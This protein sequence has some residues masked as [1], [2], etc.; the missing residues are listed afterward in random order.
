MTGHGDN[1]NQ[2]L[3]TI[4]SLQPGRLNPLSTWKMQTRFRCLL[5]ILLTL[6]FYTVTETTVKLSKQMGGACSARCQSIT[7]LSLVEKESSIPG[8]S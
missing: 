2:Q 8:V 5:F 4:I 1:I 3:A 7:A 6:P